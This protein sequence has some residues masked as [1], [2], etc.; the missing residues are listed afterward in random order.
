MET[1][2][3]EILGEVV[4]SGDDEQ[5]FLPAGYKKAA[6]TPRY[7]AGFLPAVLECVCRRH[8]IVVVA[9]HRERRLDP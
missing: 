7:V 3:L 2:E 1:V 6:V 5:I 4:L 8:G 9:T